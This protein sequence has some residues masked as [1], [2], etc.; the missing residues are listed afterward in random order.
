MVPDQLYWLKYFQP[1]TPGFLNSPSCG[2][3]CVC[4]CVCVCVRPIAINIC[5]IG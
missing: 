2:Y 4:V 3:I 5:M 1:G